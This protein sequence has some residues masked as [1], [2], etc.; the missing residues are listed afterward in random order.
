MLHRRPPGRRRKAR[1][2]GWGRLQ[3]GRLAKE[4]QA[5]SAGGTALPLCDGKKETF[6][7]SAMR[8]VK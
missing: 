5:G 7:G 6:R 8:W 2:N 1:V 4:G 3:G